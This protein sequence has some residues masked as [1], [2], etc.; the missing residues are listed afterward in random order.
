MGEP[1]GGQRAGAVGL[2]SVPAAVG[3]VEGGEEGVEGGGEVVGG[4]EDADGGAGCGWQE[5]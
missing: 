3:P 1:S 2:P 5:D 4:D